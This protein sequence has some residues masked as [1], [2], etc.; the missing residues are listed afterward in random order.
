MRTNDASGIC[1]GHM[2]LASNLGMH[3]ADARTD[4]RTHEE[5]FLTFRGKSC[6]GNAR[7]PIQ[8][9]LKSDEPISLASLDLGS[10]LEC[11]ESRFP[12][13]RTRLTARRERIPGEDRQYV[14]QRDHFA[15][16]QCGAREDLTLDH[17]IPWSAMGS[18]HVDNLRTLCWP[19]N[20]RRSNFHQPDDGWRPLPLTF[21]CVDCDSEFMR[22]YPDA[23]SLPFDHPSMAK[24]FCWWH[25][26]AAIGSRAEWFTEN[27]AYW[28][29]DLNWHREK[30]ASSKEA[31]R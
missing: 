23:D 1:V 6:L 11:E 9:S 18:D 20:E 4:G 29:Y 16:V 7:K 22:D 12:V 3:Q 27:N 15:C 21:A 10:I 5:S 8:E 19:C 24:C 2:P 17:I 13:R 26:H 31:V 28:D 30:P 14:Y 25:R